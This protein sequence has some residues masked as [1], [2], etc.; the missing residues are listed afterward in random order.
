[1]FKR[2]VV[3]DAADAVKEDGGVNAEPQNP[4]ETQTENVVEDTQATP[5][6]AP[7]HH[8]EITIAIARPNL[9]D[10]RNKSARNTKYNQCRLQLQN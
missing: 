1:M 9:F 6:D 8:G 10:M 2:A 3:S 5:D 7:L 4:Q